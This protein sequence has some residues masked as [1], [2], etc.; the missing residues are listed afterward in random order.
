M[1]NYSGYFIDLDG[2]IYKGRERYPSGKRFI[3]RLQAAEIDYRFVTNNSTKTPEEV[4]RNLTDNHDIPTSPE[5]VYTSA[6]ATADFLRTQPKIESVLIIGEGGL[7]TAIEQA[8]FQLVTKAP[9]DAVVIALDRDVTYEKLMEA[10]FAIQAGARF[11]A[12]NIDTNL[13]NELGMTPGAGAFV[14]FIETATQTKPVVIGKPSKT[15]IDLAL[16]RVDKN[17]NEVIM[18]GDNYNTDIKAGLNAGMDTLLVYTGVAVKTDVQQYEAA[19][20]PTYEVDS[21]DDWIL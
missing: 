17:A 19:V 8:G 6:M 5:Q 13:P 16:A 1:S 11:I 18:V 14:T 4:A 10:T 20:R 21:L 12:T 7:K 2:T 15:I 3:E 9:A